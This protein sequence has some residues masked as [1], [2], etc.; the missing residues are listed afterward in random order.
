MHKE[1]LRQAVHLSGLAFV[2]AAQYLDKM[3][4][5]VL[6]LSIGIFFLVYSEYV[7]RTK[8]LLGFRN[9]VY[10][11]EKRK[12]SRPFKGAYWFYIGCGI[13]FALFPKNIASAASA[14]LAVGDSFS[15]IIGIHFGRHK[16][17]NNKSAEGTLAFFITAF[18]ASLLFVN[19]VASFIGSAAAA[20]VELITPPKL[21]KRSHW[22][23]DDNLLIPITSGFGILL[24]YAL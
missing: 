12:D 11:F 24:L 4:G 9:F 6:F 18:L 17:I 13:S 20:V 3:Q 16:I 19:P 8:S 2:F 15:T 10:K 22:I 23:L 14:I 7:R 21:S 1:M 5:A